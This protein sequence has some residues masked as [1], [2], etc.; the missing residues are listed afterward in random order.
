MS[1]GGSLSNFALRLIRA[2]TKLPGDGTKAL[3][4]EESD[5]MAHVAG[6]FINLDTDKDGMITRHQL[7]QGL[8]LIGLR[9]TEFLLKKFVTE[10]AA[11]A[12]A[13]T[14]S[15]S[16]RKG[17]IASSITPITTTISAEEKNKHSKITSEIFCKVVME[18]WLSV[19]SS[20]AFISM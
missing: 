20:S 19:R 17:S 3:T 15:S 2:N 10:T 14:T 1:T 5:M 4:V 7:V 6:V 13:A 8:H 16:V 9:P 11:T 18:E 12:A